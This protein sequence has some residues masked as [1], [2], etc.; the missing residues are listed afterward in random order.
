MSKP[1]S[2]RSFA[3]ALAVSLALIGGFWLFGNRGEP[4][5]SPSPGV[6]SEGGD[7]GDSAGRAN[8]EGTQSPDDSAAFQVTGGFAIR[9]SL[10]AVNG[11]DSSSPRP[12]A[13]LTAHAVEEI[14]RC[15]GGDGL[16]AS[17]GG[18]LDPL[19]SAVQSRANQEGGPNAA[20]LSAEKQY[21][22]YHIILPSGEERRI[23]V[24]SDSSPDGSPR[25]RL[26]QYAVDEEGL[27]IPLSGP[28]SDTAPDSPSPNDDEDAATDPA[29][30]RDSDLINPSPD[31][32]RALVGQG[33]LVFSESSWIAS[34]TSGERAGRVAWKVTNGRL[35]EL[36]WI[37]PEAN[38]GCAITDLS[39][40]AER[41]EVDCDCRK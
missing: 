20:P 4:G 33:R 29:P 5:P 15:A 25:E 3:L 31:A 11:G 41:P 37:S 26:R 8:I 35:S 38:L 1:L 30:N 19:L 16:G 27:P 14:R 6:S 34:R 10:P 22:N 2:G 21:E 13:T 32:V 28:G 40:R 36:Q 12:R 9:G 24:I 39:G 7:S 23:Q 17:L 18:S